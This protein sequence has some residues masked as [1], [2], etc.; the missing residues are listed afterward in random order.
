MTGVPLPSVGFIGLGQ[1]GAPM[2]ANLLA[3]G[4]PLTVHTRSRI[5]EEPLAAAGAVR[6]ASP[7]EVATNAAILCLCV[8]DGAAVEEV[9]FGDQGAAGRMR[10]GSFVIDFSTIEPAQ[11]QELH[12]R[13]QAAGVDCLDA[14]LQWLVNRFSS[15]NARGLKLKCATCLS[16]DLA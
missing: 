10:P 7:A 4:Y 12:R 16:L 9:L 6:V 15:H 1:L 14:G 11:S 13:L 5:A 8:S 3:A 2:A